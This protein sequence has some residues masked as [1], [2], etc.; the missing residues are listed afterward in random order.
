MVNHRNTSLHTLAS[1]KRR[2]QCVALFVAASVVDNA[3]DN[4]SR[5]R[6]PVFL[7]QSPK[8]CRVPG[9]PRH[10]GRV[11]ELGARRL[12]A[13]DREIGTVGHVR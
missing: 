10:A 7:V 8:V 6:S 12:I 9:I 4:L 5:R 11:T 1:V 2:G 3:H 13:W